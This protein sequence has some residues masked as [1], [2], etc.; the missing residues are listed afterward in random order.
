ML[1][2]TGPTIV[3]VHCEFPRGPLCG[4]P[5]MIALSRDWPAR[6]AAQT[7]SEFSLPDVQATVMGVD[8]TGR[9]VLLTGRDNSLVVDLDSPYEY[10]I[11]DSHDSGVDPT[12]LEWHRTD[13]SQVAVAH[14][15]VCD[16]LSWSANE[17]R[18]SHLVTLRGYIRPISGLDWC[19]HQPNLLAT[20][21][22]ENFRAICIWD[23]RDAS[24]PVRTT[25]SLSPS[26]L[27][28]WNPLQDFKYVTGHDCM[29]QFWD[30]RFE[31]AERHFSAHPSRV[32]DFDWSPRRASEFV[33]AT[34]DAHV[35]VWD[36]G[37][38]GSP[39]LSASFKKIPMS[40]LRY[41]PQGTGIIGRPVRKRWSDAGLLLWR[42]ST[43]T[44]M[45]LLPEESNC[46]YETE[47]HS[48][49][50]ISE[51]SYVFAFGWCQ[52]PS[53]AADFVSLQFDSKDCKSD[54]LRN[55]L[56]SWSADRQLR[57]H[58]LPASFLRLDD[59]APA[60]FSHDLPKVLPVCPPPSSL[61]STTSPAETITKPVDSMGRSTPPESTTKPPP[62][63][64][65]SASTPGRSTPLGSQT[66][67]TL[68]AAAQVLAREISLLS[69]RAGSYKLEE[70]DY[71]NRRAKL[72][73]FYCRLAH[74]HHF[75]VCRLAVDP[76]DPRHFP[77]VV[78]DSEDLGTLMQTPPPLPP[79][80]P[81]P[82]PP[83]SQAGDPSVGISTPTVDSPGA[84][85]VPCSGQVTIV[86]SFPPGYSSP[87]S[88]PTFTIVASSPPLHP[89]LQA[90]V[91]HAMQRTALESV[92]ASRGC[93][94][95]CIRRAIQL[96]NTSDF[97]TCS[98]L[99]NSSVLRT[100]EEINSSQSG[101]LPMLVKSKD[102]PLTP[103]PLSAALPLAMSAELASFPASDASVPFPRTSGARISPCGILVA[104]GLHQPLTQILASSPTPVLGHTSRPTTII[105]GYGKMQSPRSYR[106]FR[107]L[108]EGRARYFRQ[109]T[110]NR[111]TSRHR[112]VDSEGNLQSRDTT[113]RS[114]SLVGA[115]VS[116]PWG[117]DDEEEES[118]TIPRRTSF[119]TS[120]SVRRW[121]KRSLSAESLTE[122]RHRK[123][124]QREGV[125]VVCP[126]GQGVPAAPSGRRM[127]QRPGPD[128]AAD[129][130]SRNVSS[131][132]L[133]SFAQPQ[134][135]S[136]Q[137]ASSSAAGEM[138]SEAEGDVSSHQ[139]PIDENSRKSLD[140]PRSLAYSTGSRR[141]TFAADG[142]GA[143]D[144][145]SQRKTLQAATPAFETDQLD[146]G[147]RRRS[148]DARW[149][150]VPS[151]GSPMVL[152]YDVSAL[153]PSSKFLANNY[154]FDIA[155][156]SSMC[157]HNLAVA[158]STA[159][160]DLIQ[161]WTCCSSLAN[162]QLRQAPFPSMVPPWA[163]QSMGRSLF[164]V[165]ASHFLKVKDAQSLTML[166][167]VMG[168]L[169][170]QSTP[171]AILLTLS[172]P[173]ADQPVPS[174]QQRH[175]LRPQTSVYF[176]PRSRSTVLP[177]NLTLLEHHLKER[178]RASAEAAD[179]GTLPHLN[180]FW[181][182][183]SNTP[184][185]LGWKGLSSTGGSALLDT[186]EPSAEH[187][188][189]PQSGRRLTLY[190][191][192]SVARIRAAAT[193]NDRWRGTD[194]LQFDEVLRTHLVDPS[195]GSTAPDVLVHLV[196]VAGQGC[197]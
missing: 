94:E 10:A 20:S 47:D 167:L 137:I 109:A 178:F 61:V 186:K 105:P 75:G 21:S 128:S 165:W 36:T 77:G 112:C 38:F 117:Y 81:P 142:P 87:G 119:S 40:R 179:S 180:D 39:M 56:I 107:I 150:P 194:E 67:K 15:N 118:E 133:R 17:S 172:V 11:F 144:S 111:Q 85:V 122:R 168:A 132:S 157:S 51:D 141:I 29:L 190:N 163:V 84:G 100:V 159:R 79:P 6:G 114:S 181:D 68:D 3:A 143:S 182:G 138:Q 41:S 8:C 197:D 175:T 49:G 48:Q 116:V 92:S 183:R 35:R 74:Y 188:S 187:G 108:M 73:L 78:I 156:V 161:F 89:A 139:E 106:E 66:S 154:S 50:A 71:I 160:P 152:L 23:L 59:L 196:P 158:T 7:V 62:A 25:E 5:V 127:S 46:L 57:I 1:D 86:T 170:A 30:L 169:D 14:S 121:V 70:V 110:R 54:L 113:A 162:S 2:S 37:D 83:P 193:E 53:T 44:P 33:L 27:V 16:V 155:N 64:S 91:L 176:P 65:K 63:L 123:E 26:C 58:S 76:T 191:K 125:G 148:T 129:D 60:D 82:P 146:R 13:P 145:P 102:S 134:R 149:I 90:H 31:V 95:P 126:T 9:Y 99:E 88:P 4:L 12:V 72:T 184:Q 18:L 177:P 173:A 115:G 151:G 101:T 195:G 166:G 171:P 103:T 98:G 136:S 131:S 192:S 55:H 140:E 34:R 189:T 69:P 32:L 22:L 120:R 147:L 42:A 45:R 19:P 52:A 24:R 43:L 130:P 96:L 164:S 135:C 174:S 185:T 153:L 97:S 93:M 28:R 124:K 80:P 104:F